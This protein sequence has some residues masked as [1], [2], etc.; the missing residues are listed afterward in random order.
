MVPLPCL[1]G[2]AV[3][4]PLL[5]LRPKIHVRILENFVKMHEP[6]PKPLEP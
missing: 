3:E 1:E 4:Q 5:R 2:P 6:V